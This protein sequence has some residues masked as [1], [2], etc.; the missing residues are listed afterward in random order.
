MHPIKNE[1]GMTF[2]P[3]LIRFSL[4]LDETKK[5]MNEIFYNLTGEKVKLNV[6]W[7]DE[8]TD[9]LEVELAYTDEERLLEMN[10]FF[11]VELD[12][13]FGLTNL[14][15]KKL[16]NSEEASHH[17]P[18]VDYENPGDTLIWFSLPV[19]DYLKMKKK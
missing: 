18:V 8:Y 11:E 10:I 13:V 14:M 2:A 19:A 1:F 5:A 7:N 17:I 16:V 15:V 12:N 4:T 6:T 9:E 3:S